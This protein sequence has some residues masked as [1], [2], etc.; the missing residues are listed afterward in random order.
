MSFGFGVG[1]FIA[2]IELANKFRK[3]FVGA[4]SQFKAISDEIRSLLIVLQDADVAYPNQELSADQ[5]RDL[6]DID[7]GCR[8]VLD[9]LQR[10]V[11]K[12]SEVGTECRSV[13][14]RTKRVWK[15]FNWKP[16][17]INE[18]R[19]RIITN[20]GLLNAFNG[21]LT[22]DNVV[23]LVQHQ[24]DQGRQ[25]V[26]NWLTPIDF[27]TQ[28]SDFISRREAGTGQ[29]LLESAEF[30]AW[31]KTDQ[32]ALFCPGIP[33]AGKTILTSIVVDYLNANFQKDT[34][35]GIAYLYCNFRRQNEQ[36]AEGLLASL[37][38]Q[39]AQGLYP[40]PESVKSLYNSHEKS[41]TRPAFIELSSTLQSVAALY[42][43]SFIVVDALDE[44]QT[45][46]GCR[47]K[48]LTEIFALQS[49]SRAG[50]F[51][52]S[53]FIPEIEVQFKN[54]MRLEI[55]ASDHDVQRYLEGHMSELPTCVLR[56]SELQGE[57]KTAIVKAVNGMFLLAQL[58]FDSLKGKKS[59]KA[60][61]TALKELSTG[62]D[63]YDAAYND[64]MERIEG[65]LAGEKE[66]SKQVLSWITCAKRPL[67]TSELEHAL[68]VE[69]GELQ[70][71][72]EN[73]SPIE[74][75]VSV[76]AGLVTVDEESAI[77]RLVH[78]TTQEYFERTQK[79]WF[80]QAET[81]IATICVTYLSFNV[82][83][84][85][86]CQ[87]D[88]E[89]EERLQTNPLYDYASHN[90]GHHARNASTLIQEVII[91]LEKKAQVEASSQAL[92][93]QNSYSEYSQRYPR[94][95]TGLHLAAYFGQLWPDAAVLGGRERARGR[96]A[97]AARQG[98]RGGY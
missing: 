3:E 41:R 27:A 82:F 95:M 90:W 84:T 97:A 38:K 25:T 67:T 44:C 74:D 92:L 2:A 34:N 26:L 54:G 4:P 7:K 33:G 83:E 87:N 32:Q 85:G 19:S 59:P 9:E 71:D 48:L 80:P 64:A 12:N 57:I 8:N 81:D 45:S 29:W 94:R 21:R 10:I 68:A 65:Q 1:D 11:D 72:E 75:M 37:L 76:C 20:I 15:R 22:R 36:N 49:K 91:F 35:T 23:K 98:R 24:E 61:R 50:I 5:K 52:T 53:R 16:D 88:E 60:I 62:N 6:E 40:L 96:R 93:V 89:F 55:Q 14:E 47:T 18:L 42:S 13:G 17:D 63:A 28:Q 43:R 56:N 79:R 51:S 46:G 39:L 77:I 31:V 73:L 86:F 69:L 78:Y 58:H 30:Q 70:F 66:L